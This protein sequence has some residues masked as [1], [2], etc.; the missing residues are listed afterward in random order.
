MVLAL[1]KIYFATLTKG[2]IPLD[3]MKWLRIRTYILL[4]DDFRC[5]E[6]GWKPS[7]RDDFYGKFDI[8]HIVPISEGG[9]NHLSNLR[10][11]C[12]SCHRKKHRWLR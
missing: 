3:S 4:R 12:H 6:C 8:D 11:I 10:L 1:L 9:S 2:R 7:N 5:K